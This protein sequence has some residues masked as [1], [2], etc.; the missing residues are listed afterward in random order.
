M[1]FLATSLSIVATMLHTDVMKD[2]RFGGFLRD[3][4]GC[5]SAAIYAG[6]AFVV[7]SFALLVGYPEIRPEPR[8]W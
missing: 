2:L 8:D 1:G 3:F 5:I 6:L 4:V 7:V